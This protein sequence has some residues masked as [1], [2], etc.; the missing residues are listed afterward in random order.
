MCTVSWTHTASGFELYC[1]RDERTT[2]LPARPPAMRRIRDTRVLT[3]ADG[4][5]GGTWTGVNELGVA[6]SLLNLYEA[7][8]RATGRETT[9]RGL[10][11]LDLLDA[12]SLSE[13]RLRIGGVDLDRFQP[14][15]VVALEPG[16]PALVASWDGRSCTF[17]F[18]G[19]YAMPL[20]SSGY[21]PAGV[22]AWRREL[23]RLGSA[24]NGVTPALLE[25]FHRGHDPEA[26]PLSVCM[27]RDDANT[28]SFTHVVVDA[29]HAAIAYED[30]PP[31]ER[32]PPTRLS[33]DRVERR[34]AVLR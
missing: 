4:D 28:V 27:H 7:E 10:L 25:A 13:V 20:V 22:A 9:S 30:G 33:L 19:D 18:D 32:R 26:G 23:L 5:F 29:S 2:R 21:D 1:N 15:T 6:L 24:T 14:F 12:A 31:C 17:E 8:N 3:P 11:L 16:R 34:A